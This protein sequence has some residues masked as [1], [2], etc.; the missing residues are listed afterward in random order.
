METCFSLANS[1]LRNQSIQMK[2]LFTVFLIVSSSFLMAQSKSG[3]EFKLKGNISKVQDPARRVVLAYS[4]LG[5]RINDTAVIKNGKFS[6]KG[7]LAEPTRASLRILVDSAEAAAKGINRR[8]SMGRDFLTIF[9]DKGKIKVA[10]V[11]SF[12]NSI[13]KGSATQDEFAKLN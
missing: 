13:V 5:N 6:F 2:S 7:H 10:T 9:L 4:S 12:S 8:P 11:D 1:I 3:F